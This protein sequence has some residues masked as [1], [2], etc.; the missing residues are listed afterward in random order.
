MLAGVKVT[1]RRDIRV[2]VRDNAALEKHLFATGK[3]KLVISAIKLVGATEQELYDA[4]QMVQGV[5]GPTSATCGTVDQHRLVE[6]GNPQDAGGRGRSAGL[7]ARG[8]GGDS[9]RAVEGRG[10]AWKASESMT[11]TAEMKRRGSE[12]RCTAAERTRVRAGGQLSG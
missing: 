9:Q 2:S 5:V 12:M 10:L 4:L 1:E 7:G 11:I 6:V 3:H 8:A